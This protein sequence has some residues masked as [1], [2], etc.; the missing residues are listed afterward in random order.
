MEVI[1]MK[2]VFPKPS[3]K[4]GRRMTLFLVEELQRSP[5]IPIEKLNKEA[6]EFEENVLSKIHTP[7]PMK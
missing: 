5:K 6:R 7:E 3:K 4:M 1:K 2:L